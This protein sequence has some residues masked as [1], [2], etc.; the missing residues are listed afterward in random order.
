MCRPIYVCMSG[1]AFRHALGYRAETWHGGRGRA[2]EVCGHIF[3]ATP[4]GLK[5]IEGSICLKMPYG[6]QIWLEEPLTRV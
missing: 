6:Q 1:Y 2:H 3:E 4:P 5:V